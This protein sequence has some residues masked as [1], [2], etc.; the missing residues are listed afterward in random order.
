MKRRLDPFT[1]V[2]GTHEVE[3]APGVR[4]PVERQTRLSPEASNSTTPSIDQ[5][6]EFDAMFIDMTL[7]IREPKADLRWHG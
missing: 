4:V 7:K 1:G 3:H 5:I 2:I 6:D